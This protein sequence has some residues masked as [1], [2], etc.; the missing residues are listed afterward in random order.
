MTSDKSRSAAFLRGVTITILIGG[1]AGLVVGCVTTGTG[2]TPAG[3]QST[4]QQGQDLIRAAQRGDAD[5][6][7]K[8]GTAYLVRQQGNVSE[9]AAQAA[10][11]YRAAAN[12]GHALAQNNL[13]QL[14]IS[15]IGVPQNKAEAITLFRA[16]ADQGNAS[17]QFSIGRAYLAG[18]GVPQDYGQA[19]AWFVKSADQGNSDAQNA[20]GAI[21]A[22]G[23]GVVKDDVEAT[24]WFRLAAEKG[25]ATAQSNLASHYATGRGVPKDEMY[26]Y[27]WYNLA[28]AR[29]PSRQRPAT[30]ALRDVMAARLTP[31][32][33]ERAQSVAQ[34]WKPG[35]PVE[36]LRRD[37]ETA[38][39]SAA[40]G[41]TASGNRRLHSTGTGFVVNKKGHVLTNAHV[42]EACT[43]LRAR[44]PGDAAAPIELV[45]KD[46]RNDLAVLKLQAAPARTAVFRDG[47]P[48]RQGDGVVVYG[49]PLSGALATDGNVTTG[50]VSAL[51]GMAN[52]SRM[53]QITAPVQLGNSGGP[54]VDMSGNIVGVIVSKL[55]ALAF[56]ATAGDIPQNV[57]FAIKASVVREFLD[58]N[59]VDYQVGASNQQLQANDVS[60]RAKRFTLRV[61][62]WR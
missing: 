29:L 33:V 16:S 49:Y 37:A 17:G 23:H 13:G 59:S 3:Q 53:L 2:N 8:L 36:E 45:A 58:A 51:A 25:N 61:E 44:M 56:A 10:K 12:Q 7:V 20:L 31:A 22:N 50:N 27:F 41:A 39:S 52:D 32:E 55:N 26:A 4:S 35:A 24:K 42:V 11:W 1:L 34:S 28:A 19:R 43:E 62:C 18:D 47:Q 9:N 6:Q 14:Y 38:T 57:S 60:D 46:A 5:A 21:Y 15:G 30:A 40:T 48:V 54:L